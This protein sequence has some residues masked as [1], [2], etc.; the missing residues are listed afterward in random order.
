MKDT[1]QGKGLQGKENHRS[2]SRRNKIPFAIRY[3]ENHSRNGTGNE[4]HRYPTRWI[5]KSGWLVLTFFHSL[6]EVLRDQRDVNKAENS[7]PKSS[8]AILEAE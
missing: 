4:R 6:V 5:N 7:L 2:P 1:G 3:R 8:Y